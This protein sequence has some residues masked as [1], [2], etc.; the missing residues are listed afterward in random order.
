MAMIN[1]MNTLQTH[2]DSARFGFTE[3]THRQAYYKNYFLILFILDSDMSHGEF[4]TT[5]L[6]GDFKKFDS[7]LRNFIVKDK[8]DH[9]NRLIPYNIIRYTREVGVD[10]LPNRM[11]W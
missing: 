3:C 6:S 1:L 9:R 8:G 11:D 5:K 2:K 10:S 4:F 7:N